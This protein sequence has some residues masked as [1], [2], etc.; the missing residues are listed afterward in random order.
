[1]LIGWTGKPAVGVLRHWCKW[2][3]VPPKKDRVNHQI[4]GYIVGTSIE[5]RSHRNGLC[6]S[7]YPLSKSSNPS[8][9]ALA[10]QWV[11][12]Y[13]RKQSQTSRNNYLRR[14]FNAISTHQFRLYEQTHSWRWRDFHLPWSWRSDKP[15]SWRFGGL[16]VKVEQKAMPNVV[17]DQKHKFSVIY[18]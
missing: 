11:D 5:C 18:A 9:R 8:S 14:P 3:R 17:N 1:M 2:V 12:A 13:C 6:R 16:T 7:G 4:G 15:P 10:V